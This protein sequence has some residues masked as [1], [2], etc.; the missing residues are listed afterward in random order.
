[1]S[2]EIRRRQLCAVG[3]TTAPDAR[4]PRSGRVCVSVRRTLRQSAGRQAAE[5]RGQET[6]RQKG[7]KVITSIH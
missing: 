3:P 5:T 1:M 2:P 4:G 6:M 7:T